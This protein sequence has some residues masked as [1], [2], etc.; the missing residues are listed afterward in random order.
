[1]KAAGGTDRAEG[2]SWGEKTQEVRSWLFEMYCVDGVILERKTLL[3]DLRLVL[4]AGVGKLHCPGKQTEWDRGHQDY[5]PP[6][7]A[8]SGLPS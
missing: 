2:T 6:L 3:C 7:G 1:M 4:N 8:D 5:S